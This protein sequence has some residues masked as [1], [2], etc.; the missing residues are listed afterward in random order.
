M[1]LWVKWCQGLLNQ[2]VSI[3][4]SQ[5]LDA[6]ILNVRLIYSSP[7]EQKNEPF[8]SKTVNFHVEQFIIL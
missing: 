6:N 5:K 3:H 2:K 1:F 8:V 7:E 4:K